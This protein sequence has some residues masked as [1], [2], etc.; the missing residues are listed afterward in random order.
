MHRRRHTTNHPAV[1]VAAA[2]LCTNL[3]GFRA[4]P[5]LIPGL[6][7]QVAHDF[8]ILGTIA[9]HNIAIRIDEEGIEAHVTRQQALLAV[10]VVDQ[11]VVK[12]CTEPLLR[13][14][15]TEQLVD[16]ILEVL[17]DHR[18]VMDDVLCLNEVEAVM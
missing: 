4:V 17:C 13:T 2:N 16:Q 18:T 5:Q 12:I 3:L 1:T 8:L 14:V 10:D 6:I 11:T 15:A 9:R 7:V